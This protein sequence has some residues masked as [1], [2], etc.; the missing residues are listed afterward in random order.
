VSRARTSVCPGR[1]FETPGDVYN[2]TPPRVVFGVG[3]SAGVPDEVDRLGGRRVLIISTPGRRE[4]AEH[5][6]GLLSWRCAAIQSKAVSQVPIELAW[7]AREEAASLGVDCLVTVGGGAATGLGKAVALESGIPIIAIPTTYSGSEMTGFCGITIDGVKRMHVN[8]NMLPRSVVYDP[9]LMIELSAATTASS[10]MNALAHCVEALYVPTASPIIRAAATEAIEV[11]AES[12]PA[13]LENPRDLAARTE[14]L[15]GACLAGAALTGGFALQHGLAHVLGATF[16]I[17]HGESHSLALPYVTAF[18]APVASAAMERVASAF[19]A[20]DA[21]GAIYDFAVSI[22]APICL[23][24]FGMTE[25]E[26]RRCA[27]IVIETDNDL[28]PRELDL[29]GVQSILE[30]ALRGRRPSVT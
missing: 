8:L 6:A 28:N 11:I 16:G 30:D 2:A 3:T 12:V 7:E 27:E 10:A 21:A 13:L 1:R 20:D 18:N 25:P 14:V 5:I 29:P 19:G 15:Y 24:D 9:E 22:G 26:L 23:G 4:M 17:P